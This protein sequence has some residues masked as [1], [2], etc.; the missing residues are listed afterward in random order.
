MTTID[1]PEGVRFAQLAA[2]KGMVKLELMGLRRSKGSAY[3]AA[4]RLYGLKGSRQ[5]V[6]EQLCAMVELAIKEAGT[7]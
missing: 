5:H 3:A 7:R 2:I 4:K 6:Y 1:T